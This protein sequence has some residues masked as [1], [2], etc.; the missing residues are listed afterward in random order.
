MPELLTTDEL[1]KCLK[2]SADTVRTWSRNGQI[3]TVWLSRNVRRFDFEDVLR[4]LRN[5]AEQRGASDE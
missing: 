4:A 1:A 5:R 3:P 2:L